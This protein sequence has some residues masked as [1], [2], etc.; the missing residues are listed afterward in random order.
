M[1]SS[2]IPNGKNNDASHSNLAVGKVIV[3][4][5]SVTVPRVVANV[6]RANEAV[7]FE[8]LADN[9]TVNTINGLPPG[10]GGGGSE[11]KDLGDLTVGAGGDAV[12]CLPAGAAGTVL[13]MVGASPAW[14][15]PSSGGS[16]NFADMQVIGLT[17]ED[18]MPD[19]NVPSGTGSY[20]KTYDLGVAGIVSAWVGIPQVSLQ[21]PT[22]NTL[23]GTGV[24]SGT[25]NYNGL[26]S[27]M[28]YVTENYLE[29]KRFGGNAAERV[30]GTGQPLGL[31]ALRQTYSTLGGYVFGIYSDASEPHSIVFDMGSTSVDQNLQ[32]V[33]LDN[34][35]ATT[36]L[37]LDFIKRNSNSGSFRFHNDII[38]Y[39]SP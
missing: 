9:L 24:G 21:R 22:F 27:S 1:S 37:T 12:V 13:T 8:L 25:D 28:I 7:V 14:T 35:G 26:V 32:A 5:K 31:S 18:I 33:Y 10:S 19:L 34:S 11:C 20:T 15:P 23:A 16:P 29:T 4:G 2:H 3:A 6:V 38:V 39:Y 30:P 17:W 36:I